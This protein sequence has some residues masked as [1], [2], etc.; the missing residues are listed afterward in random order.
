MQQDEVFE[1][2]GQT[3]KRAW[4]AGIDCEEFVLRARQLF[5]EMESRGD[6]V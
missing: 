1:K 2:L 5:S 6:G 3:V 4:E